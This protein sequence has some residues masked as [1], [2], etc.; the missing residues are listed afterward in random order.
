[1][2]L[3]G[4]ALWVVLGL[5]WEGTVHNGAHAIPALQPD[6]V[7]PRGDPQD[8]FCSSRGH[9]VVQV[10]WGMGQGG[11]SHLERELRCYFIGLEFME[12]QTL[13]AASQPLCSLP[14]SLFLG[15]PCPS[16][17][18]PNPQVEEDTRCSTQ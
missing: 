3:G 8:P 14:P 2:D 15:L 4:T 12:H 6:A 16:L 9:T 13:A 5:R 17:G 10:N 7:N 18:S 1:M 11:L